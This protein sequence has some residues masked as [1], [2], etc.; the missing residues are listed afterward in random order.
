MQQYIIGKFWIVRE[1]STV[2]EDEYKVYDSDDSP[3]VLGCNSKQTAIDELE[4]KVGAVD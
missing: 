1:Y 3:I 2:F 4:S